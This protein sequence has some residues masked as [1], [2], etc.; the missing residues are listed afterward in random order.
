MFDR[1]DCTEITLHSYSTSYDPIESTSIFATINFLYLYYHSTFFRPRL[2]KCFIFLDAILYCT[3]LPATLR[4]LLSLF[5]VR[6]PPHTAS[7][8]TVP[9]LMSFQ[10]RI[11]PSIHFP[12]ILPTSPRL[13]SCHH[14][15]T[16]TSTARQRRVP[17]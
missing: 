17:I 7:C 6:H 11:D 5:D 16:D 3:S 1:N 10:T 15:L 4:T 2:N 8:R 14:H 9:I 12:S 13:T